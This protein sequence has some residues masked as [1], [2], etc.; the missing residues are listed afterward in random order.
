MAASLFAC[1]PSGTVYYVAPG[2]EGTGV[3]SKENPFSSISQALQAIQKER[4]KGK[5]RESAICF[6]KGEYIISNTVLIDSTL[7]YIRIESY[8]K[9]PVVFTGG[10]AIPAMALEQMELLYP[11]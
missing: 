1:T 6:R 3:G 7:S 11:R 4:A 5:F 9:E 2:G 8:E 10:R